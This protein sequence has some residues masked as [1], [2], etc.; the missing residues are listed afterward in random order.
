MKL[1]LKMR[2]VLISIVLIALLLL[3]A[4]CSESSQKVNTA[5]EPL[6][7]KK[8][9]DP[10]EDVK[11]LCRGTVFFVWDVITLGYDKKEQTGRREEVLTRRQAE[12]V[13]FLK[14]IECI[15]N[16]FA[17][18]CYYGD[19][20]Y[21]GWDETYRDRGYRDGGYRNGYGWGR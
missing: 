2:S 5:D 6:V 18:S 8:S 16:A 3:S 21:S 7:R 10:V 12:N 13:G 15:A 4:G 20:Y 11:G 1:G 14:F 9:F 19:R 17:P